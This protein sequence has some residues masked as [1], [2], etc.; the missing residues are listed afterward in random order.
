MIAINI[1]KQFKQLFP[2]N[3]KD[4][5]KYTEHGPCSIILEFVNGNKLIFT[6]TTANSWR[7]EPYRS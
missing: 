6:L 1:W 7:L 5:V 3:A 2:D 4:V